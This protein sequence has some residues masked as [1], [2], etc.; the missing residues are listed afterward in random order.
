VVVLLKHTHP[1]TLSLSISLTLLLEKKGGGGRLVTDTL[2]Q[3]PRTNNSAAANLHVASVLP[4]PKKSVYRVLQNTHTHTRHKKTPKANMEQFTTGV[5]NATTSLRNNAELLTTNVTASLRKLMANTPVKVFAGSLDDLCHMTRTQLVF[6]FDKMD[7]QTLQDSWDATGLKSKL[8]DPVLIKARLVKFVIDTR[9]SKGWA[10][11]IQGI[12]NQIGTA[13]T[14]GAVLGALGIG[15]L[16]GLHGLPTYTKNDVKR[17][18]HIDDALLM[19][20][21]GHSAIHN[22][23]EIERTK[24]AAAWKPGANTSF[25]PTTAVGDAATVGLVALAVA[26]VG[27]GTSR[28]FHGR[29]KGKKSALKAVANARHLKYSTGK[30]RMRRASSATKRKPSDT[31]RASSRRKSSVA[32]AA[33][34]AT[35]SKKAAGGWSFY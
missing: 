7:A 26:G 27:H 9:N 35:P 8:T 13:G 10:K 12:S 34:A 14:T 30:N 32:T 19:R 33:A 22:Q 3:P 17:C 15:T 4:P 6:H 16:I 24:F 20:K 28:L 29:A 23:F 31:K 18:K 25:R 21:E 1:H 2:T 5:T 11:Y